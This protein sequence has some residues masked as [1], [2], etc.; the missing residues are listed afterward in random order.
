MVLAAR[1]FHRAPSR[2]ETWSFHESNVSILGVMVARLVNF[3]TRLPGAK[4][5]TPRCRLHAKL[6]RAYRRF[7]IVSRHR[8]LP[9]RKNKTQTLGS[10]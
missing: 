6:L 2:H 1:S 4:P 9:R 3:L 5:D 10:L 8:F 7:Q